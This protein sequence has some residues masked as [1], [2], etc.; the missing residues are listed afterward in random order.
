MV[1]TSETEKD[2]WRQ[3]AVAAL[4]SVED[5]KSGE[6]KEAMQYACIVADGVLRAYRKRCGEKND[7]E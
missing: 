5:C 4:K 7:E 2:L 1:F 6:H 3:A